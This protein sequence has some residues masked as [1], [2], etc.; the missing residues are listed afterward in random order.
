MSWAG[1]V[2]DVAKKHRFSE[3]LDM[4]ILHVRSPNSELFRLQDEQLV[5]EV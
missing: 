3:G 2:L 1:T 5:F 4:R